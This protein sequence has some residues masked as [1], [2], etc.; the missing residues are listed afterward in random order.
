ML[1]AVE[2][3]DLLAVIVGGDGL[4]L[5]DVARLA[6]TCRTVALRCRAAL[7]GVAHA[8]ADLARRC[9]EAR[10]GASLPG[11]AARHVGHDWWRHDLDDGQRRFSYWGVNVTVRYPFRSACLS[12]LTSEVHVGHDRSSGIN[13]ELHYVE[14]EKGNGVW[15]M[16]PVCAAVTRA[17]F[18]DRLA[19]LL[20]DGGDPSRWRT[21]TH[22]ALADYEIGL[23]GAATTTTT[24]TRSD[25][26]RVTGVAIE[27]CS[28][29]PHPTTHKD[30]D[31]Q[32]RCADAD[33]YWRCMSAML[34]AVPPTLAVHVQGH[35]HRHVPRAQ[36]RS[37]R[38]K[39]ET[40]DVD[41]GVDELQRHVRRWLSEPPRVDATTRSY[42]EEMR[43]RSHWFECAA[44][45]QTL[46]DPN[47]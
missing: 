3:G 29:D 47:R 36:R 22:P 38:V 23:G 13:L 16:T 34:D 41:L 30:V 11:A 12:L 46:S 31:V 6:R 33:A 35:C 32:L 18:D 45:L 21:T 19:L 39:T 4:S 27:M 26:L 24:P 42:T 5:R 17:L 9:H 2:F 10:D 25:G 8:R 7:V 44:A 40:K 28:F 14:A 37:S 43:T 1:G 15:R 20:L